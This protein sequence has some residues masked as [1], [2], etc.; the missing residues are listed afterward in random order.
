VT[1][2]EAM[3]TFVASEGADYKDYYCELADHLC[4]H[5]DEDELEGMPDAL[6][7]PRAFGAW[8]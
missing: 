7:T 2:A 5:C 8:L 6:F 1:K 4:E 3:K